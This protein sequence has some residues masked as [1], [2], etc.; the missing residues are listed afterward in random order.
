MW[1]YDDLVIL[2]IVFTCFYYDV[3][4]CDLEGVAVCEFLWPRSII[5]FYHLA[6]ANN[7]AQ[8]G[9]N[10]IQI[11]FRISNSKDKKSASFVLLATHTPTQIKSDRFLSLCISYLR[12]RLYCCRHAQALVDQT[13]SI[14]RTKFRI[15]KL[16]SRRLTSTWITELHSDCL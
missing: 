6:N 2:I 9:I 16:P 4:E 7:R 12:C 13:H 3:D 15:H 14:G 1:H 5:H 10:R 8:R 11:E